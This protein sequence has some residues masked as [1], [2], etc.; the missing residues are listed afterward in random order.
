MSSVVL[1]VT[2]KLTDE[3]FIAFEKGVECEVKGI[4]Q[5]M[6]FDDNG[7]NEA[8]EKAEKYDN[9][10]EYLRVFEEDIYNTLKSKNF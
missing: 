10:V 6:F 4:I 9:I 1:K 5:S 7:V 2:K 3:N 8:I